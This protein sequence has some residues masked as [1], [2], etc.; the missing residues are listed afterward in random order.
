M[1][2]SSLR[3]DP[4]PRLQR[5]RPTHPPLLGFGA[6]PRLSHQRA[7]AAMAG[8]QV[9]AELTSP[10]F[11]DPSGQIRPSSPPTLAPNPTPAVRVWGVASSPAP[12][13]LWRSSMSLD[14]GR[15]FHFSLI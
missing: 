11:L 14:L 12:A 5:S 13:C 6:R 7:L 3:R 8:A 9:A 10:F 1:L 2:R 15:K 4:S